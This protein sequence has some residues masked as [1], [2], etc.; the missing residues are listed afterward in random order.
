[1]IRLDALGR[2]LIAIGFGILLASVPLVAHHSFAAEF[3]GTKPI[4]LKGTL[5]GASLVNPHGWLHVDVTDDTLNGRLNPPSKG[6]TVKWMIETGGVNAMYRRGWRP[7]NL[8]VGKVVVVEGFMA[9]DGSPT[10][11]GVCVT[12]ED[13]RS[14]FAGSSAPSDAFQGTGL[15]GS[16]ACGGQGLDGAN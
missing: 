7:S 3:D 12:F 14:L 4:I 6:K 15:A 13:G 10:V 1:M 16:K 9:K 11:N 8:P 5:T 2:Y